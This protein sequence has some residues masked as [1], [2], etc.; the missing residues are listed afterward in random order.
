M[1]MEDLQGHLPHRTPSNGDK[2]VC[3]TD[4]EGGSASITDVGK[5]LDKLKT[6]LHIGKMGIGKNSANKHTLTKDLQANFPLKYN[7]YAR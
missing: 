2:I 6:D 4:D 5:Y 7:C 1:K 3:S